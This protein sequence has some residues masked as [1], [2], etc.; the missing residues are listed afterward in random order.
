MR[1]AAVVGLMVIGGVSCVIA[2]PATANSPVLAFEISTSS[3]QAGGHPNISTFFEVGTR[4]SQHIPPPSCDCQDA[5]TIRV[6]SPTGIIANPHA[7]PQCTAVEF[8]T[9]HCPID[10]QVGVAMTK[11]TFPF[12]D[13]IYNLEPHFGQPGLIGF[14]IGLV[15]FPIF[16][17]INP[18]TQSDY[19]LTLT[20]TNITHIFALESQRIN[21]WGVPADPSH[22]GER[23]SPP[24]CDTTQTGSPECVTPTPSNSPRIPFLDNPTTCGVPLTAT[25]NVLSYDNGTSE[26][27][28]P[29]PATTGCDQLGFNPSLF[30][31]PTTE[32]SDTASGLAINL[33]VPQYESPTVPSPSEIR[34]ATITLPEGFSINPNAA[35]GKDS[36]SDSEASFGTTEEAQCPEFSKVGTLSIE[37]SALPG[38][39]PGFVYLGQPQ[40]GKRYRLFL[41]A[42]GFGVHVK[43]AGTV[44]PNPQTGQLVASFSELPQSPFSDFNIHLFGSERGL[45]ATPSQCGTF[46]V[47]STFTPWDA[48]LSQQTSLQ[49]F[50]LDSGPGGAPCPVG[51]RPFAPTFEAGVTN[52]TAG[53]HTTFTLNL[54]R[55]DGD[56]SLSGL[57]VRTPAGFIA[58]LKGVPYCSDAALA[59]AAAPTYSG[60][61]EETS[62]TCPETSQ[63]GTSSAGAGAGTHP[64][65]LPGKVYLSGPYRGAPL[66][67]AVITPAVTGPYDLGNVVVRA[68][69]RVNPESAQITAASDPLPQIIEGIPLRL[70]QILVNLNR[71]NFALNP[72]NCDPMSISAEIDGSEGSV[73]TPSEPFQVADCTDLGFA[74]TLTTSISGSTNHGGIPSLHTVLS[75]P[76][77][78][79][80]YAN[81]ARAVVTLPH[82]EFLDNAHIKSPCTRVQFNADQC[83]SGSVIG[84]AKAE[85]PLLEKPLE[86]PVYLRANGGERKLPDIV[87]ALRG[88]IDINLV[89]YVES[90]H[91]QLRTA[92]ETP[93]DAPVSKF[94]LTLDG[95]KKGI[96]I[97]SVNLCDQ[98]LHVIANITG[99]N[100]LSANQSP[101]LETQCARRSQHSHNQA[102]R[103]RR[104]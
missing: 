83:P 22:D 24:G 62:P 15:N 59:A 69:L 39:L 58:T 52:K 60:L 51:R 34:A 79:T 12:H 7:T 41:T 89:G 42:N 27:S 76:P 50:T 18:R 44:E 10:S 78:S 97:N 86:G 11:A 80:A 43:I 19:G 91:G 74:P 71:P 5:R 87:A 61:A 35:D 20:A 46:P 1:L 40:P 99:Q 65:Y 3:T 63:I 48:E 29:Y 85:T 90:T 32:E 100:G 93:P 28:A 14:N 66:S 77:D 49:Y 30:A 98:P 38:P 104:G 31:Q 95:G 56:Q 67:L 25:I 36:C 88:Q 55:P 9:Q 45:L 26:A 68:A 17:V 103:Q 16:L 64:V 70:R 73:A 96:L 23:Y 92:F 82:S 72:T 4:N 94:G 37:S 21:L 6:D 47:K 8:G 84:Y 102:H 54:T 81:T 2:A 33:Q 101:E 75:Y 13:A 57:S 53:D